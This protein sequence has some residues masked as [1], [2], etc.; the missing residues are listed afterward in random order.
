MN[1][2]GVEYNVDKGGNIIFPVI[3]ML[4]GRISNGE[5]GLKICGRK[6]KI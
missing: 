4:L 6:I 5:G 2:C 1:I 3:L